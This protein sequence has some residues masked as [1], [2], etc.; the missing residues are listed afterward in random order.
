MKRTVLQ[1]IPAI[2]LAAT[3]L[4]SASA[5]K[6]SSAMSAPT[7]QDSVLSYDQVDKMPEYPGGM[8]AFYQFFGKNVKIP[9]EAEKQQINGRV[10]VAFVV[11]EDGSLKDFKVLKDPGYGLSEEVLRVLQKSPKWTPGT[12]NGKN[13]S[14]AYTLPISINAKKG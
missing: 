5:A 3:L 9:S 11:A 14:V 4:V 8:S 1:S 12:K 13:V 2:V 7:L 6:N 10:M